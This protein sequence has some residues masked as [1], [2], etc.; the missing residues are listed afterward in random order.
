[1]KKTDKSLANV[2]KIK[3][4][5]YKYTLFLKMCNDHQKESI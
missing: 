2:I 3:E 5:K 1:M 4:E